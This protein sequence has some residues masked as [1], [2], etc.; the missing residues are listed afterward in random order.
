M[1]YRKV[2]YC[3]LHRYFGGEV[4]HSITVDI[5]PEDNRQVVRFVVTTVKSRNWNISP[6]IPV[7]NCQN[8][9][10][11]LKRSPVPWN[12]NIGVVHV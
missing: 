9:Q 5:I 3:Y 6:T 2:S 12:N 8:Y 11:G 10:V 7:S 1:S 4:E